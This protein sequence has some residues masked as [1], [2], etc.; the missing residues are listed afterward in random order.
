MTYLADLHLHSQYARGCSKALTLENLAQWA[1]F[2]GIDLLAA[3]DFTH[4]ARFQEIS[5]T[6]TEA[7]DGLLDYGGVR[8]ILGTEVNCN[9]PQGGRSRR[10]H[11][12]A[13]VPSLAAAAH[14]NAR[15]E[16]HG[17]LDSD[18]RPTLHLTPRDLLDLLLEVDERCFVI[19]AHAWTPWFGVFGSK[20]GFDSLEE[21][22]EDLTYR[23]FAVET[24]LSGDPAMHW[25]VPEL[26][27]IAIVSF[28]DAHSLPKM[29]RELTAFNGPMTFDGLVDALKSGG[30]AY[31]VEFFPESGKYH[32]SG[33]RKCGVRLSPEQVRSCGVRCAE[34]GR[35]VTLGVLERVEQLA[36]RDVTTAVDSAGFVGGVDGRPPYRMMVP[37]E[38]ILSEALGKGVNTKTVQSAWTRLVEGLGNEMSVLMETP[39]SEIERVADERVAEGIARV[40]R[41]D[42]SISPGY[43]GEYGKVCV[44]P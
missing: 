28:S 22:F 38:Q 26:D 39:E 42:V 24:G 11:I 6:L 8:F 30:V 2:K 35:P 16:R 7:D 5:Q 20:S 27:D 32:L 13:F 31:T 14:F 4:S 18:G 17:K 41:G 44:W 36:T 25:R 15:I 33:H 40:R 21:C 3:G 9:A 37:L 29:G 43:D 19:P 12:L 34:C 1:G 10:T 23:V